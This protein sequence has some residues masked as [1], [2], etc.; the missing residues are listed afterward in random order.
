MVE[1][2]ARIQWLISLRVLVVTLLLGLSLTFQ[3]TRGEQVET[4]YTLIV[5]TYAVTIMYALVLRYVATPEA[6]VQLAWVQIGI[7]FLLETVLIA[8]TGGIES[9]F[10]VLYVIS[11]TLASLVPRRKVGLLTASLCVILFGVLTNLQLYGLTEAWGWLPRTRLSAPETLQTFGVHSL[12]LLVVGFLSGL[13]T[14]Q[15]QRADHSLREKEQGLSRLQAFHENI[16]HSISSGVF[17]TDEG[18]RIT[19]FNPAAQEATGYS[20]AQ[21][22]GHPWR[23]VFNWHPDQTADKQ[24]EGVANMRFEVEC[25]RANGNRLV[26]GMTLSPLQERGRTT[27]MVGVFK[28]LT[29]IR[30]LEE[31]M[32][33]KEWLASLGEM[34]AGMAHEIRNPLGALAGAMQMLRKDLHAD[35]TS[36]RLMDIAIR[37]ATRLDTI[38]TEF[39]QYARPPALNL[40]EYDLNKLLAETLDL[41]QHEARTRTNIRIETKPSQEALVGQVD[42][43][44]L[45]QVF[46]NLATNAF[47]AM[48]KGG[49]LTI[50]TGCRSIDAGGRKGDVIEISFQ[51]SGEGISKKNLDN[52]FLPFFTTKKQGSGLGLAA[53]HR[54]VDLHGGWIKVESKEHEGSRF[55]VCLPRSADV[56]VRLWH[57]GREPWKRS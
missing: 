30:D 20:L 52:I 42:Q 3:V 13:L 28:D 5:F 54:I 19:S 15:L 21:V 40:G 1:I 39:L 57:E 41:V 26:L 10:L 48:P 22:Q 37:E 46:W 16:V 12:A 56:G 14:E 4:F 6:L 17:T 50:A 51:D 45:K 36:Q 23:D 11:V 29:Q 43:D 44:Q 9:P 38:I 24:G 7:D 47:D 27:G 31:E 34:S 25:T 8:R 35:E 32:R 55:V 18:G 49:Q 53:V 33:R 2:K